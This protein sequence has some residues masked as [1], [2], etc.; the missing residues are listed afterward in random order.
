[1]SFGYAGKL[2]RINL[3][4][5]EIKDESLPSDTTLR[6]YLGCWGLA[7]RYLYN[8]CP[9]GVSPIDAE[10]PLIFFYWTTN[11]NTYYWSN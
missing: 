2:L 8:E 3:T 10:N 4:T 5:G 1:M 11:R 6:D 9:P 7:L